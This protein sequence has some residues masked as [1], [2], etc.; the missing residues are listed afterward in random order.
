[1]FAPK[2]QHQIRLTNSSKAPLT[3]A[4]ALI[5]RQGRLLAQGIVLYTP[6]G[7]DS[8]LPITEA[9]DISVSKKD[10]ETGRTPNAATWNGNQYTRVDLAGSLKLTNHRDKKVQVEVTRYVMGNVTEASQG[11]QIEMVNVL[12]DLSFLPTHSAGG[13]GGW[14]W[15][16]HGWS[17]WWYHFNGVG[18]ISWKVDLP[19]GDST[20]LTYTW[21][22]FWR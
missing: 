8:D 16:W 18:K 12:E 15:Q 2:V 6:I 4:P 13:L 10:K 7:G 19:P 9:V 17:D 1:M 11:G 3:T 14:W 5:L 22:Y 20:E 21:N